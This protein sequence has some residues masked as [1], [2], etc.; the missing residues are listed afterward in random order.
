MVILLSLE[1][2]PD[3]EATQNHAS[4]DNFFLDLAHDGGQFG[5]GLDG[6]ACYCHTLQFR[7]LSGP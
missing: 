1:E 6:L 3:F 4:T 5:M 2:Y 7:L